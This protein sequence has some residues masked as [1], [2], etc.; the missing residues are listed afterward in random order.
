M[1]ALFNRYF[2]IVKTLGIAAAAGLAASAVS[3]QMGSSF[4]L[5]S[6]EDD[7][8]GAGDT[9][10]EDEDED[11]KAD[12]TDPT[13]PPKPPVTPRVGSSRASKDRASEQVRKF[14]VFCPTCVPVVPEGSPDGPQTPSFDAQGRPI[15]PVIQPGEVRS[16]LPLRL[17]ATMESVDPMLSL[18]T[19]YDAD[20]AAVGLYGV[21]DVIRPGVVVT[22]IDQGVLHMRNNAALEYIEIGGAIPEPS[23]APPPVKEEAKEE[24]PKDDR[25]IP[26]AEDSINCP[27]E[28]LCIVERAFVESLIANPMALAKQARIVPA[29]DG[30]VGFKF[31]GIRRG[32]LPKLLGLKN[33]D[34]LV[35]VNGEELSG[36]DQV[37]G[38]FTKLRRATNL[39]VTIERKG[40]SINK[41][42]QIQ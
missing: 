42:I 30:E 11:D 32:S 9:D 26:G 10:G 36:V 25:A 15:G 22:G 29:K 14:N 31:Y 37:M 33:G 24:P 35:A 17:Q 12:L 13:R 18:A 39:Q 7:K 6:S 28:N 21:D 34:K 16:G 3:T 8:A 23:A 38:M 27:N 41:E 19:V 40:K 2:W 4:V 5:V 20:T 1:E